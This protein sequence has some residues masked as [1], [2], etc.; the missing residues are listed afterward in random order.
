MKQTKITVM[1]VILF[2]I[3]SGLSLWSFEI[4]N[5]EV[6]LIVRRAE[7]AAPPQ[8]VFDHLIISYYKTPFAKTAAIA[9]EHEQYTR[10]HSF[11]RNDNGVYFYVLPLSRIPKGIDLNYRLI[12]D[13]LWQHDPQNP[14]QIRTRSG[15]HFS[16]ISIP[17]DYYDNESFPKVKD[18]RWVEFRTEALPG[19][20]V[21]LVGSFNNWDPFSRPMDETLSGEFRTQVKLP[22]GEHLYYFLYNGR[23]ILD[24][25]NPNR[26][27]DMDKEAVNQLVIN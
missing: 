26:A 5:P 19:T 27:Y 3:S 12:I 13:G 4:Q 10:L 21:T 23:K 2:L 7:S 17:Q 16:H 15:I 11:V 24:R 18:N 8:I 6:D 9:F 25:Q 22:P 20:T 1:T 14:N